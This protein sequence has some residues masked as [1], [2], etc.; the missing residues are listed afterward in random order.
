MAQASAW[1]M[2]S[3]ASAENVLYCNYWYMRKPDY[4]N[5]NT[6]CVLLDY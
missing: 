1:I 5:D 4:P 3:P 6:D 2:T